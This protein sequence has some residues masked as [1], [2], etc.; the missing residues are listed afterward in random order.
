MKPFFI[1]IDT[2]GDSLWEQ[3]VDITTENVLNIPIF[4]EL[5][6]KYD[7]IPIWLTDYEV[8]CD[9]RFVNYI[10]DKAQANLCEIGIHVHPQNNPPIYE[11]ER[12][13]SEGELLIEYPYEIMKEKV[14]TL[15]ELIESR[16][17]LPVVSHRAGRWAF[18]DSYARCIRELGI[19]YDCS[20]T[21]KMNWF[22]LG[23]A[24]KDSHGMD[25]SGYSRKRQLFKDDVGQYVIEY[26][27]S[28]FD[29]AKYFI[30]NNAG[31]KD[32]VKEVVHKYKNHKIWLR[33]TSKNLRQMK[34][35]LDQII[36]NP[37]EE[38][39]QFMIHSSEFK[40]GCNHLYQTEAQMKGFFKDIDELFKYAKSLG[41]YGSTFEM[42][43]RNKLNV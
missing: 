18:S 12:V 23:G 36:N 3:T 2:E 32:Y 41:F 7:F 40:L 42:H 6:E 8:I 13:T 19:K 17:E 30:P 1:T 34:Y 14:R 39:A 4:Q 43:E 5:C 31:V 11:L 26:P 21:P 38:F 10:K 24:T 29:H 27:V 9:D 16:I 25:F 20:V 37:E 35:I 22:K 33:P 28:I 15:K